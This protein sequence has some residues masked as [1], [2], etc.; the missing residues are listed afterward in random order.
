MALLADFQGVVF[1]PHKEDTCA[2]AQEKGGINGEKP[3][4]GLRRHDLA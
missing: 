3:A 1:I 4:F 2:D